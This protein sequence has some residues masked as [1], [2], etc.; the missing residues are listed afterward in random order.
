MDLTGRDPSQATGGA[1]GRWTNTR[2]AGVHRV[3]PRAQGGNAQGLILNRG[4]AVGE[5]GSPEPE[6]EVRLPGGFVLSN[7]GVSAPAHQPRAIVRPAGRAAAE[8]FRYQRVRQVFD[9]SRGSVRFIDFI[10][11]CPRGRR[12]IRV[13]VEDGDR[14]VWQQPDVMLAPEGVGALGVIDHVEAPRRPGTTQLPED[15]AGVLVDL[16]YGVRMPQRHQDSVFASGLDR[17]HMHDVSRNFAAD[18]WPPS[19]RLGQTHMVARIP[20]PY[21][22]PLWVHLL[23]DVIQHFFVRAIAIRREVD[24]FASLRADQQVVAIW[25]L[26]KLMEISGARHGVY[27]P[28]DGPA[29]VVNDEAMVVAPPGD[30][31]IVQDRRVDHLAGRF[32]IPPDRNTF[33]IEDDDELGCGPREGETRG[34]D[35]EGVTR[36]AKL[37]VFPGREAGGQAADE[38][39]LGFDP[40]GDGE[41][42]RL[43]FLQGHRRLEFAAGRLASVHGYLGSFGHPAGDFERVP[44]AA[45]GVVR[46]VGIE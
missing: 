9:Q 22:L 34:D 42:E 18:S 7:Q 31:A 41:A 6:P 32:R 28:E 30:R 44:R 24:M 39:V 10:T 2:S 11:H 15:F 36:L 8:A 1:P 45:R 38:I 4:G 29:E 43:V 40:R 37:L 3:H 21:Q 26:L 14:A 17:I 12:L 13:V 5:E 20:A 23:D 35:I 19:A 25:L 27:F 33:A 46:D 16:V